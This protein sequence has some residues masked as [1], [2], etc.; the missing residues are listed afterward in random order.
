MT[1]LLVMVPTRGRSAQCERLLASFRETASPATDILFILDPDDRSYD[2]MDFGDAPRA[3][4]DPRAYL[5]GEAE[6]DGRGCR[7]LLRR[8]DVARR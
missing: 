4:L 8:A 5:I 2:E 7:G 6:Q 1:D 3:V